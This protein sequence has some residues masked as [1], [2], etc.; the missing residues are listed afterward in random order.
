M[1]LR[2]PVL[3]WRDLQGGYHGV[4]L[5]D[6][7]SAAAWAA[8]PR[9]LQEEL[10]E[11]HAWL[12]AHEPWRLQDDI[13]SAELIWV[14]IEARTR[15]R[16]RGRSIPVP[17]ALALKLPCVLLRDSHEQSLCVQPQLGLRFDLDRVED[18]KGL[19]RHY[20]QEQLRELT[21][22]ELSQRL[23]PAQA[24][25]EWLSVS[26][27]RRRG[28]IDVRQRLEL[29][30]LFEVAEPLLKERRLHGAAYGRDALALDLSERLRSARG[31]VLLVG[32]RGVGKTTLLV[33]AVRRWARQ[34]PED[35]DSALRD[36]R[37]WRFSGAR[38]VAGMQFLG[39]WEER[40]EQLIAS[41]GAVQGW[42]AA[43]NLSE[44]L[45]AGGSSP[46]AGV[47]AFLVPYL[48]RGELR[49]VA[50]TSAEELDRCRRLLPRLIDQFELVPVAPF[51]G[52]AAL[53]LMREVARA[54]ASDGLAPG[55]PEQVLALHQRFQ[56]QSV[57]PGP[58]VRMLR[59]LA[60]RA[61][62]APLGRDEVIR[63]YASRSGLPEV[64]LRDELPLSFEE[65]R[66]TL[67]DAII[68][69]PA[70]VD[71]AAQCVI[72]LKAGLNDPD[73]PLAVL[74]LTGPTGTGKTALARALARYCFSHADERL[75]RLDMS[76]YSGADA[77]YRLIGSD[78]GRP[79]RWLQ[80]IERQPFSVLLLD[81][82][83]KAAPE[84]FDVLLGLMD[85]GRIS[86]HNGRVYDFRSAIV[87]M[88]SNLGAGAGPGIG[89]VQAADDQRQHAVSAHFRPEFVNRLD[90]IVGFQA[91][92]RDSMQLI[93]AK[94]LQ[95][96]SQREGLRERGLRLSWDD[97]VVDFLAAVGH[98]PRYG[99]R[100]LQRA[101]DRHIL[102]AL[103]EWRLAQP[104]E[105]D[106]GLHLRLEEGRVV[107]VGR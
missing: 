84:V 27:R 64:L 70:A 25:I 36:Y 69:Q 39:Q 73:R 78:H 34:L 58:A 54:H 75:L 19:A 14:R 87:L 47:G 63:E 40:C 83:E 2:T 98:D 9:E 7:E 42:L 23:P 5:C 50:E 90:A 96:L 81:E 74:L 15:Y 80:S 29:R 89:F 104:R 91:L 55:V 94:E 41:V 1:S 99:A 95:D 68:G 44:L 82:I 85:E 20:A 3:Q 38:V 8:D 102:S 46:E 106:V 93:A 103:A 32:P 45:S 18:L 60:R 92:G 12:G 76:E 62:K 100:P 86:D 43:E 10:R 59:E 31:N 65:V 57:V 22:T 21:P 71:A 11:L 107:V 53:Q 67:A 13:E 97:E 52:T 72:T 88:T 105:R 66:G 28:Q 4:L 49:M 26:E 30:V 77:V 48:A 101:L 61:R 35:L 33:E 17:D 51:V 24:Q 56:P 16:S 79:P 6:D 37:V